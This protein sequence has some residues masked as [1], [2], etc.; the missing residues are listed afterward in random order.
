MNLRNKVN[1]AVVI[2]FTV[3]LVALIVAAATSSRSIMGFPKG[4]FVIICHRKIVA[5]QVHFPIPS[6]P[7]GVAEGRVTAVPRSGDVRQSRVFHDLNGQID[8]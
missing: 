5:N 1:L 2:V 6:S 8:S 3:A 7:G 4:D